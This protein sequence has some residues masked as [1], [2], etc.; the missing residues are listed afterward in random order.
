ML[1]TLSTPQ[2]I[3]DFL[4]TVP[5]NFEQEGETCRAPMG[6]LASGVAHCIEGAMLA[7]LAL[8]LQGEK[9]LLLDLTAA[10][11]DDDHVVALFRRGKFWGAISKTNHA[12]LRYRDPIYRSV[13][14]LAMSYFHEYSEKK[15]R[16]TLRSY[17]GPL[18]LSRFDARGWMTTT[19]NVWYVAQYCV[20]APHHALVTPAQIRSLRN[21]SKF[22]IDTFEPTQWKKK[23]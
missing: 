13:R 5:Y 10:S 22:E 9:P 7:A 2:K 20:D 14:E 17:A 8:R 23:K 16:K 15:G 6:V 11:Y 3:Q 21:W 12:V 18:N 4:D 1:R 19:E